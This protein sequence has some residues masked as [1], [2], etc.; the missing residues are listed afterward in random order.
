[1]VKW[2]AIKRI[3]NYVVYLVCRHDYVDFLTKNL[4][5]FVPNKEFH[6][7]T[8]ANAQ[9]ISSSEIPLKSQ[10]CVSNV[11]CIE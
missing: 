10:E 5:D 6:N 8:D 1:M 3:E 4:T 9:L 11:L 2:L 7:P